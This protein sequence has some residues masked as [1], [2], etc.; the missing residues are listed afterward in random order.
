MGTYLNLKYV[1]CSPEFCCIP[2]I[3]TLLTNSAGILRDER[4]VLHAS[5]YPLLWMKVT[6]PNT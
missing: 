5:L 2:S 4:T 6:Q 1:N 3:G